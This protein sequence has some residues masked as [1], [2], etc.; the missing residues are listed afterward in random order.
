MILV[1]LGT[2]KQQFTRILDCIENSSV[3]EEVIVQSGHTK[4]ESTKMKIIDFIGY[5]E[6]AELV[7]KADL[8]VTHGGTGSIIGPLKQG[9]KVIACARLQKYGEH[10]D[11]HQ[12]E[13]VSIF[14]DEGYILEIKD[15]DS[16]DEIVEKAKT[17]TPK[18]YQSNTDK[19]IEKLKEKI[20]E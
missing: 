5:D 16:F 18:Q 17:F 15:G 13:L 11:N 9:K 6:M 7:E 4:Y 20:G 3:K 10:I 1:T 8:I 19:F 2:Q 12:E 14:S